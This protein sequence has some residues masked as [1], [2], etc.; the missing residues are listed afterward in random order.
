MGIKSYSHLLSNYLHKQMMWLPIVIYVPALAFN[1][2][3]CA[4]WFTWLKIAFWANLKQISAHLWQWYHFLFLSFVHFIFAKH[5]HMCSNRCQ[6]PFDYT[7][8]LSCVHILHMCWWFES[9]CMDGLYTVSVFIARTMCSFR[10]FLAFW[11][12]NICRLILGW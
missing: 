11:L 6:C 1:Q 8:R 12:K 9:C 5:T 3:M 7:H 2:G 4:V 10:G